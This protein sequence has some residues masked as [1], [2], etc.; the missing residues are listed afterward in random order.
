LL[1]KR[2]FGRE[3]NGAVR[4][5]LARYGQLAFRTRENRKIRLSDGGG[6]KPVLSTM[7]RRYD[8]HKPGGYPGNIG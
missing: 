3:L 5:A 4:G 1:A 7:A 2:R 8:F 6:E